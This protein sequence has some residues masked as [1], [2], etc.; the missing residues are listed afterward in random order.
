MNQLHQQIIKQ[1]QVASGLQSPDFEGFGRKYVG[2]NKAYYHTNTTQ[3]K[4]IATQFL[5]SH[6]LS[7]NELEELISS[8]Y[9]HQQ[10]YDEL[11]IA[12]MLVASSP[13]LRQKFD[14]NLLDHWLSF[15]CGWAETDVL[16][17]SPF[18]A[19]DLLSRWDSWHQLLSK[20]SQ[21]ENVHK[22]RASLVLL[23][24]PLRQSSDPRLSQLAFANIELLKSEKDILITKAISWLLRSLIVQH[25]Q[26]LSDYL[27]NN[28]DSLP[29]IAFR[30]ATSKL[31]TGKKYVNQKRQSIIKN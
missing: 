1:L 11:I 21:D 9:Q 3:L 18:T 19:E 20:L 31:L 24:K 8:L 22:R 27:A 29:K 15:V 25:R 13:E 5:K 12:A 17:Q 16:C 26:E 28:Q 30:E 4:N 23:T 10:S 14:L 7:Q 2:T 6:H